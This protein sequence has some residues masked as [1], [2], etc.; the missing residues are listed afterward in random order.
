[1]EGIL[2]L[3]KQLQEDGVQPSDEFTSIL[4]TQLRR[5]GITPPRRARPHIAAIVSP[6]PQGEQQRCL[7]VSIYVLRVIICR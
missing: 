2:S 5:H 6:Q 3:Q 1:M 4:S 7:H